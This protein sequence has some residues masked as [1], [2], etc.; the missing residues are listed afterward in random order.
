MSAYD[1]FVQI[2]EA[3]MRQAAETQRSVIE[4]AA[5]WVADALERKRF[6]FAFG[7]GHSHMIAEE[8]FY[9]AGGLA[10]AIPMLEE[11]L[12]LHEQAIEA[13]YKERETGYAERILNEYPVGAGD[14]L[15][16]VSNSGRNAVPIEL[17]LGAQARGAKTVAITN[18]AQS[19]A[20][21]SRHPSGK[22]LAEVAEVVIDNCGINGDAAVDIAGYPFKVGPPSSIT[23]ML[24]INLI[25]VQAIEFAVQRGV[26]PDVFI[27][28]NTNGDDHNGR[29][30]DEL[31]PFNKHL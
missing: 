16:V 28:S 7:T 17:V 8:I 3:Q 25:V 22:R 31:R 12:M 9:R 24:I 11:P 1:S 19:F 26:L 30:L 5:R 21:P 2:A 29:L 14:V 27:S 4:Q 18:R 10:R 13:T 15:V 6:L 23:G 20:W